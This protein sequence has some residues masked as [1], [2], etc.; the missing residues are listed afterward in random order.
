M[1]FSWD[2][3]K[4]LWTLEDRALDFVRAPQFFDGRPVLQWRTPRDGEERWKS[5]ADLDG[6][7]C[8]IVWTW[9]DGKIRIISMRQAHGK[10]IR[11]YRDLYFS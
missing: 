9:R 8:T 10:E 2:E 5:T 7:V 1:E 3:A 4:R 6:K 11:Q